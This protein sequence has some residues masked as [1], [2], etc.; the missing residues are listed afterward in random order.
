[1]TG[2]NIEKRIALVRHAQTDWNA[3]GRWQ[4]HADP[5]LSRVGEDQ[6]Q[7]LG[8]RLASEPADVLIASDLRRALQTAAPLAEAWGIEIIEDP[9]LRELDVGLWSGQTRSEIEERD[10]ETL[11]AFE[12][13]GPDVRPGGGE[14]RRSIRDRAHSA[15]ADWIRRVPE[16]RLVVVTHLGFILALL[17]GEEVEN[18]SV[19][20]VT[21]EDLLTRR[22]L[23]DEVDA[24]RVL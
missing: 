14:S 19:L 20:E 2:S 22:R 24:G 3:A 9:R 1:M 16:G 23:Q 10:P 17:P 12:A 18:A 8:E 6:A 5:P 4:G 21:E 7:R 15:M 11:A 13:G